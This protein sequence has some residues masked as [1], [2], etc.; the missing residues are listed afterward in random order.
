M[1]KIPD[2][3]SRI[4]IPNHIS[5]SYETIFGLKIPKFFVTDPHP[6]LF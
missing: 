4:S 6:G 1:E 5:E 3:G 2:P